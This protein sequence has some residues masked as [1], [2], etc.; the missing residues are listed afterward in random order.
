MRFIKIFA[1]VTTQTKVYIIAIKFQDGLP[2][3]AD[4]L[5]NENIKQ[6]NS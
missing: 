4:K 5:I 1:A 3:F 6:Q 2:Y